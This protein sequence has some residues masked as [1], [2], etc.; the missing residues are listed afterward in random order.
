[1]TKIKRG[2]SRRSL[3]DYPEPPLSGE[4]E[5]SLP[6]GFR[7]AAC[8][9]HDVDHLSLREHWID[10]FLCRYLYNL[11]RENLLWRFRPG[12]AVDSYWG[13]LLALLG[14]D[15]WETIDALLAAEKQAGVT[16]SWFV[17]MR[18]GLGISY[19][20]DEAGRVVRRLLD[21]GQ[22]VGL[23]GQSPDDSD[24][25][26]REVSDL[27]MM[28]GAPITGL[29]MHYLR[30][31]SEV[32][33]GAQRA[34]LAY[35]S[36]VMDRRLSKPADNA[37]LAPRLVRDDLMEIPVHIM[38]SD[39]FSGTGFGLDLVSALDHC[40]C[41]IKRAADLGRLLV[42]NLHPNYYSRQSPE[43]RAWY[44]GLLAELTARSDVLITDLRGILSHLQPSQGGSASCH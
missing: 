31:T 14:H 9:S 41:L 16:S 32:L 33:S 37:L 22:E 11:A 2:A 30:L 13:V 28:T 23:H 10:G 8:L 1:M 15:R 17:P 27:S 12:R 3:V 25:L 26:A 18:K 24:E 6:P 40:R 39:L 4:F 43:T 7:W 34:G 19:G 42:I 36:T 29:R 38:D 35:D 20:A 21:A 5:L 44:D